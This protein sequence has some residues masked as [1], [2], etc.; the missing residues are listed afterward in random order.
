MKKHTYFNYNDIN[1]QYGLCDEL[2]E[3]NKEK[4]AALGRKL[5]VC[6]QTFGC[7]Q[8]EADSER[9]LGWAI[10]CGYEKCDILEDAD[11]IVFNTCAVREHAELRALSKTGQ[12][13]HLKEKNP[14]LLI[15]LWGC[16]VA[17]EH[18]KDAIKHSYPYV[19]F[20][21]GTNMLHRFPEILYDVVTNK[22]RRYYVDTEDYSVIEGSAIERDSSFRA[23]VSVM[24]GC[25][26][27]CTYCVVPYVRGRERS[28][29]PKAILD[30]VRELAEKGYKEI[31]LLG[32][33]V[34]S[35]GK[36]LPEEERIT[37]AELLRRICEIPGDFLVRFMTS[38]PKDAS[39]ELIEVMASNPKIAR[40]FHLPIQSGS[41]EV[42]KAMN[43]HYDRERY[44]EVARKIKTA[45]PDITL[46]TDIIV[47]FPGE[48]EEQF[49][50]TL[51][52]VKEVGFDSIYA[53]IFSPR[54]GTPAAEMPDPFTKEE[55]SA[56]FSRLL[57]L[58]SEVNA[59]L[60]KKLVGREM[61]ILVDTHPDTNGL[62]SGRNS[63]NKI[64]KFK[65]DKDYYGEYI[66]VKVTS[67]EGASVYA[68]IKN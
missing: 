27:F 52:A 13:K 22:R 63:G 49:E 53:F 54:N 26:N 32:Q 44:F 41:R 57:E 37:F 56:R 4:E 17:Q 8:N 61:R 36:T 19:D 35:Y 66:N 39:D 20:V 38:H 67:S 30:E 50:E 16:M 6:V 33:N 7:Q 46:T 29:S 40:H 55:K 21:A 51:S 47:G 45:M 25:N 65:A 5:R 58:E 18:R 9:I 2:L 31:T 12:L 68:E 43:R 15:G 23:W 3:M 60:G 14:E 34:N 1:E 10:R 11:L 64:I 24:Y 28:R 62:C 42:L 48:T 59:A